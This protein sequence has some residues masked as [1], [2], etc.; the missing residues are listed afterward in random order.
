MLP[1]LLLLGIGGGAYAASQHKA[2]PNIMPDESA[3]WIKANAGKLLATPETSALAALHLRNLGMPYFAKAVEAGMDPLEMRVD[4]PWA[5][6]AQ[7][8]EAAI[9]KRM[10]GYS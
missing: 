10:F 2:K 7:A 6:E 1:I 5:K 8:R 4:A 9:A 3:R